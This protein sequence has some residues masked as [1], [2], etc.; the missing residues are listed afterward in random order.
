MIEI[1]TNPNNIPD[2]GSAIFLHCS[3]DKP[4][5]GCIAVDRNVMKK[6]VENVD[7]MTSIEILSLTVHN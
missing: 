7:E 1:K 4:T 6:I 5:A 2:K 3:N